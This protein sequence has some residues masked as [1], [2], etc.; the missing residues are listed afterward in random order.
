[1][2]KPVSYKYIVFFLLFTSLSSFGQNYQE[3]GEDAFEPDS[4][5]AVR[6]AVKIDPLQFVFGDFSIY[7]ERIFKSRYSAELGIGFTRRNYAAGWFDYS[8]DN[9]GENV[10][11]E[12][13][14][15]IA[16]SLRRY[17]KDT[18]ELNGLYLALGFSARLYK[19]DYFVIDS[20]GTLTDISFNDNRQFTSGSVI[21]GYQALSIRSNIFVDGYLGLAVVNKDFDTVTSSDIN[22]PSAYYIGQKKSYELGLEVGV[23]IG[24][25]F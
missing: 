23:K 19:T 1:M 11:I 12:T 15:S 9:L 6:N 20:A 2:S 10:D 7:Y 22:D 14:Y 21:I 18:G 16:L 13:G 8:L 25:G 17:F 5:F 24:F 3:E 4:L